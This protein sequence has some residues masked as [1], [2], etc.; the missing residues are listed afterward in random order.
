MTS[1][2]YVVYRPIGT[3]QTD[4]SNTCRYHLN[5]DYIQSIITHLH[6][7][8]LHFYRLCADVIS[9]SCMKYWPS[10]L[11]K[12]LFNKK[13]PLNFK[14]KKRVLSPLAVGSLFPDYLTFMIGTYFMT[15]NMSVQAVGSLFSNIKRI[16]VSLIPSL[17]VFL[18]HHKNV[19]NYPSN[20]MN[21]VK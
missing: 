17:K 2:I 1:L 4:L 8:T 15:C 16:T 21:E 11:N 7:S 14:V 18:F 9:S 12:N 3:S 10:R 13:T 20:F 5:T 19:I 6:D